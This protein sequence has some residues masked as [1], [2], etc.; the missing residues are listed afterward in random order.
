KFGAKLRH[1]GCKARI[2]VIGAVAERRNERRQQG[3]LEQAGAERIESSHLRR[4]CS[5]GLRRRNHVVVVKSAPKEEQRGTGTKRHQVGGNVVL[6]LR[7]LLGEAS[8]LHGRR[9]R[10]DEDASAAFCKINAL[11]AGIWVF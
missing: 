7:D 4:C 6:K 2:E 8:W 9:G 10:T 3:D 5:V 11:G 1:Q